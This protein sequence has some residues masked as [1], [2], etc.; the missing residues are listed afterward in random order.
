MALLGRSLSFFAALIWIVYAVAIIGAAIG[1][2]Y[3]PHAGYGVQLGAFITAASKGMSD[4]F[5]AA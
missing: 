1:W 2:L 5:K 4:A 3:W